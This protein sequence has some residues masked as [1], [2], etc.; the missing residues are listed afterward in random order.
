[1]SLKLQVNKSVSLAVVFLL[2]S[3]ASN[4]WNKNIAESPKSY[5]VRTESAPAMESA[6]KV[7]DSLTR[8]ATI[9]N[10]PFVDRVKMMPYTVPLK[11]IAAA[12]GAVTSGYR[13]KQD[14]ETMQQ[15][16]LMRALIM[17][18][19]TKDK[20]CF[21]VEGV[22]E[23]PDA[24]NHQYWH[25]TLRT[26]T[27]TVENAKLGKFSGGVNTT[28][29]AYSSGGT[30]GA[31]TTRTYVVS[32]TICFSASIDFAA[33]FKVLIE[34]RYQMKAQPIVLTWLPIEG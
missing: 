13:T 25:F 7:K 12:E 5:L 8:S 33:Q 10:L 34:P 20:T 27:Q 9:R 28:A 4:E 21:L 22:F 19:V 30:T 16:A 1:M 3:C 14:K 31:Y 26:P 32:S 6:Q 11:T 18:L 24:L 2:V 23:N 15:N 29:H 17:D